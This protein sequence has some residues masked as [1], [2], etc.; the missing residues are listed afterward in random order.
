MNWR[1]GGGNS[2][3]SIHIIGICSN[4]ALEHEEEMP[5]RR[6]EKELSGQMVLNEQQNVCAQ[7]Q[8]GWYCWKVKQ[9]KA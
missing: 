8:V 9:R 4:V 1:S 5:G 7:F 3:W 6:G 2:V